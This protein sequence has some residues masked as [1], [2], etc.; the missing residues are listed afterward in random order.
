MLKKCG[1]VEEWA[2][3]LPILCFLLSLPPPPTS[4]YCGPV[5]PCSLASAVAWC[6]I[7]E[8][9]VVFYFRKMISGIECIFLLAVKLWSRPVWFFD[10]GK[11]ASE[12]FLSEFHVINLRFGL[13]STVLCSLT[14]HG[15]VIYSVRSGKKYTL[16]LSQS[17]HCC[18]HMGKNGHF[19]CPSQKIV[20]K[21]GG[22]RT[23]G[24]VSVACKREG[25][26]GGRQAAF[27]LT[28]QEPVFY[29]ILEVLSVVPV[30]CKPDFWDPP[31]QKMYGPVSLLIVVWQ[32]GQARCS[33]C[34]L[35]CK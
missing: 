15:S 7:W 32:A 4:S 27:T 29:F 31:M 14:A 28:F 33:W 16:F 25:I 34:R 24:L 17:I 12:Y 35:R 13:F 18:W 11:E 26:H 1:D 5:Q 2:P 10:D 22:C 19:V 6:E 9:Y 20:L 21:V 3:I 23:R 30:P 8:T